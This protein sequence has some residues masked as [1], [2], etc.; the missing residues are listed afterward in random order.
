M[1]WILN[2][3]LNTNSILV[4][5]DESGRAMLEE[6]NGKSRNVLEWNYAVRVIFMFTMYPFC[7]KHA[8]CGNCIKICLPHTLCDSYQSDAR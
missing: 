8:I 5:L 3:N 1:H 7:V 2:A 4:R 6:E